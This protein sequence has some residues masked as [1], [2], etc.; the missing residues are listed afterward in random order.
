MSIFT[1]R[2]QTANLAPYM[3][4]VPQSTTPPTPDSGYSRLFSDGT[5]GGKLTR[6]EHGGGTTL[7][8]F[9]DTKIERIATIV[10]S[11]PVGSVVFAGIP[12]GYSHLQIRGQ[13]KISTTGSPVTNVAISFNADNSGNYDSQILNAQVPTA[14][15]SQWIGGAFGSTGF[16]QAYGTVGAV[17]ADPLGFTPN[18]A[19]PVLIELPNYRSGF[20]KQWIAR[21]FPKYGDTPTNGMPQY[22]VA[23]EWRSLAA[24][25]QVGLLALPNVGIA[26]FI[27]GSRFDLYGLT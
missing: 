7:I 9:S 21:T 14:A 18:A 24:I 2:K 19:S 1:F 23:G 5:N 26:T 15:A 6:L 16:P 3:T 20:R 12:S 17:T 27:V 13:A 8:E 11:V 10:V 25:T 22:L 4:V